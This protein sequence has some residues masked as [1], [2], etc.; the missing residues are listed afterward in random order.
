MVRRRRGIAPFLSFAF[1]AGAAIACAR[2]PENARPREADSGEP[3]DSPTPSAAPATEYESPLARAAA[4]ACDRLDLLRAR[5]TGARSFR[6]LGSASSVEGEAPK[7]AIDVAS[8]PSAQAE[9]ASL[10]SARAAADPDLADL[11]SRL[12]AWPF[13]PADANAAIARAFPG[14]F[15][16][17]GP[18]L[19][20]R[21]GAMALEIDRSGAALSDPDAVA[22]LT[23]KVDLFISPRWSD[24]ARDAATSLAA[25]LADARSVRDRACAFVL[26][27]RAEAQLLAV[28]GFKGLQV[29]PKEPRSAGSKIAPLAVDRPSLRTIE[30]PGA[31]ARS[32]QADSRVVLGGDVS[33]ALEGD[34]AWLASAPPI[35]EDSAGR[36]LRADASQQIQFIKAAGLFVEAFGPSSSAPAF[37][38]AA[39][40]RLLR[41]GVLFRRDAAGAAYAL[42]LRT[43]RTVRLDDA[44]ELSESLAQLDACLRRW[45][46]AAT[47]DLS[48]LRAA[49]SRAKAPL[50]EFV[51]KMIDADVSEA[52]W[53]D[54]FSAPIARPGA[55]QKERARRLRRDQ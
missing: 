43:D 38:A 17:P 50:A 10:F 32:S 27:R 25:A 55:E 5:A 35:D 16:E 34:D 14:I 42:V 20:S 24:F 13:L 48:E 3:S 47:D 15:G 33:A 21:P 39:L 37:A 6:F 18:A 22:A 2:A 4:S 49:V 51:W 12:R 54:G 1:A 28:R 9:L 52:V 7:L 36:A 31:F 8:S 41:N 11:Q 29:E 40:K 26:K 46:D 45:R 19:G 30:R 44:L 23:S 53:T